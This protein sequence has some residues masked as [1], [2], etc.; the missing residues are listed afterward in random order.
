MSRNG[1]AWV[2][3]SISVHLMSPGKRVS[4]SRPFAD[5]SPATPPDRIGQNEHI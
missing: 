3:V 4:G 1:M 5:A 2:T